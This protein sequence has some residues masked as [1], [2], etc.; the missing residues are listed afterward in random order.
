MLDAAA[1]SGFH[2]KIAT[3]SLFVTAVRW[4]VSGG[5]AGCNQRYEPSLTVTSALNVQPGSGLYTPS[6]SST[7]FV[8]V[9]DASHSSIAI[10]RSAL[11]RSSKFCTSV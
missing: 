2:W 9:T 7:Y 3:P 1:S 11:A 8:T 4:P 6:P 5:G 10:C